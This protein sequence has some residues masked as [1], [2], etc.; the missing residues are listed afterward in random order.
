MRLTIVAVGRAKAGPEAEL[1][2]QYARRL[3]WPLDLKEVEDRKK[4]PARRMEREGQLLLAAVP[5][6]A[7][8]VAL[9]ERGKS[10]TSV[11]NE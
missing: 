7:K 4:D 6:G 5:D 3:G 1:Y 9:D 11:Q 2:R 10:L 8:L